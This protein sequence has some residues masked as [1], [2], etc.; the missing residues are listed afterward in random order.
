MIRFLLKQRVLWKKQNS[1]PF[2]PFL[3]IDASETEQPPKRV[4][5][6]SFEKFASTE[7]SPKNFMVFKHAAVAKSTYNG[8]TFLTFNLC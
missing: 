5:S 2:Y 8:I 1:Q 7:I 4:T 3:K 6:D